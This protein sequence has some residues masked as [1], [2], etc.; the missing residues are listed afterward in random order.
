MR[1]GSIKVRGFGMMLLVVLVIGFF[2]IPHKANS[3]V[4]FQNDIEKKQTIHLGVL[5]LLS[6]PA[7]DQIYQGL[8]DGLAL[9]GF[10][11]AKENIVIDVQNAQGD[12]SNLVTMS[13]KL[14]TDGNDLLVAI[15]TPSALAL[16][17]TTTELPIVMAGI[18]YPVEAG[19]VESEELPGKNITGVSDRTPI[20]EQ[21]RLMKELLPNMVSMGIL[22]TSSEDNAVKQADEAKKLAL[23]AGLVVKEASIFNS[24]D[25][26]QVTENLVA[27]VD[28]LFIPIDNVLASSMSIVTQV[29]DAYGIPVFPSSDTMVKDGGVLAVGVDQYQ[30]GL[31]TSQMVVDILQGD[32]PSQMPVVLANQGVVYLNE[33]KAKQLGLEIPTAIKAEAITVDEMQMEKGRE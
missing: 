9:E 30:I 2:T 11:E 17:N 14:V 23:E 13:E 16:A 24:N 5:Q 15:T 12:Q 32:E 8:E 10:S 4:T 26:Q 1:N 3:E 21:L 20:A 28:C 25:I 22:Y 29:T 31:A 19:L 7:L 27:Q 6:H 33:A 18:T